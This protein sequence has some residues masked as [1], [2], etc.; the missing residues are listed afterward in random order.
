VL[1]SAA[2]AARRGVHSSKSYTYTSE[3]LHNRKYYIT[4]S[5]DF[6]HWCGHHRQRQCT[7]AK[8]GNYQQ[9]SRQW[10]LTSA[11]S[12]CSA[13]WQTPSLWSAVSA[14]MRG[15]NRLVN[16]RSCAACRAGVP[17][18]GRQVQ[19]SATKRVRRAQDSVA[20][21]AH[22]WSRVGAVSGRRRC[23]A[24][25]GLPARFCFNKPT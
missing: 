12:T 7:S 23:H 5:R 9:P 22:V 3:V 21:G 24:S 8:R 10:V 18:N 1:T 4:P 11:R 6:T 16:V 2:P 25:T 13:A 14:S 15:R 20:V 17:E 19:N